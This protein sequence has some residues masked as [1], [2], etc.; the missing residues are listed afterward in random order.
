[1]RI[2]VPAP[3]TNSASIHNHKYGQINT[4]PISVAS[5]IPSMKHQ[6]HSKVSVA[7][8]RPGTQSRIA[9]SI[10]SAPLSMSSNS[11]KIGQTVAKLDP[12]NSKQT[13]L[14]RA[15]PSPFSFGASSQK[16][17]GGHQMPTR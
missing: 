11:S 12:L 2:P 1:M 8:A 15:A 13:S 5:A 6:T 10:S 16:F 7:M 4:K 17:M 3:T 9:M 14:F